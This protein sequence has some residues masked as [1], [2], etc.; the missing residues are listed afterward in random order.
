MHLAVAPFVYVAFNMIQ[1]RI[2][3]VAGS[4]RFFLLKQARFE[5][6]KVDGGLA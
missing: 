6:G 1:D 5:R 3:P 4:R 2:G